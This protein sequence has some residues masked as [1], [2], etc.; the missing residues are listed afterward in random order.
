MTIALIPGTEH[1]KTVLAGLGTTLVG[2][3][4]AK[5]I[6]QDLF[7]A[8]WGLH[9]K[10]DIQGDIREAALREIDAYCRRLTGAPQGLNV[11]QSPDHPVNYDRWYGHHG[12]AGQHVPLD[13]RLTLGGSIAVT[14]LA[15]RSRKRRDRTLRYA[16]SAA[17][18][19]VT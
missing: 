16:K 4:E 17:D 12:D 1:P 3:S 7:G 5:T 2:L 14:G 13:L 6:D 11:V 8:G 15:E 18:L 10:C 19:Y 9:A